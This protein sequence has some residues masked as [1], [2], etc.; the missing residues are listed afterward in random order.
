MHLAAEKKPLTE[1]FS[2]DLSRLYKL[3]K[4]DLFEQMSQQIISHRWLDKF[5]FREQIDDTYT[6]WVTLSIVPL[7]NYNLD[8]SLFYNEKYLENKLTQTF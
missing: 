3:R 7:N 6:V 8:I 2:N 5:L 1:L 4:N